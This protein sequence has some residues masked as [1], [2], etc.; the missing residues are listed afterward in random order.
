MPQPEF[1]TVA[2]FEQWY[3]DN[4]NHGRH[5]SAELFTV[6]LLHEWG[7]YGVRCYCG[8]GSCRGWRMAYHDETLDEL[9]SN[10]SPRG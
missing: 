2:E 9:V 4:S 1:Q 10:S 3:V 8:D 5:S 6:E 7:R